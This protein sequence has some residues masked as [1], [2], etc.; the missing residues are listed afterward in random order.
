MDTIDII[1]TIRCNRKTWKTFCGVYAND[2]LPYVVSAPCALVINKDKQSGPGTHWV[3]IFIT[4]HRTGVY[5]DSLGKLPSI[6]VQNFL[7][8]NTNSWTLSLQQIQHPMSELCGMFVCVFLHFMANQKSY[9]EFISMFHTKNLLYNDF[10]VL[11]MFHK[12][13]SAN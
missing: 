3:A 10:V 5:M 2:T 12:L 6:G 11:Q 13:C 4:S 8:R 1:N 9:H 7:H